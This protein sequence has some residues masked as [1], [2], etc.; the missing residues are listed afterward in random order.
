MRPSTAVSERRI[1]IVEDNVLIAMEMEYIVGDC[2]CAVVGP[3]SNVASGLEAVRQ[4]EIDGAVLDVNL[5]SERVWP[6]AELL[7]DRGIPFVLTTGYDSSE[8]PARFADKPLLQKPVAVSDLRQ[9]L[10]LINLLPD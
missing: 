2:G 1:L 6:V 9:A 7:D 8:V 10:A 4:T 3:V 5:G